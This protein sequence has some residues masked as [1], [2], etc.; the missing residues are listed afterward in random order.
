MAAT[1]WSWVAAKPRTTPCGSIRRRWSTSCGKWR[2]KR[3][4][5]ARRPAAHRGGASLRSFSFLSR[6]HEFIAFQ[7]FQVRKDQRNQWAEYGDKRGSR[8]GRHIINDLRCSR[9]SHAKSAQ[10]SPEALLPPT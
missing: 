9:A 2:A 4:D 7:Q 8:W 3:L 10:K 6:Q 5:V 1:P